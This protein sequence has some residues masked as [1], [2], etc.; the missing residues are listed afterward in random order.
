V[1]HGSG[2]TLLLLGHRAGTTFPVYQSGRLLSGMV[3]LAKP[4]GVTSLDVK[5]EASVSVREIQGGGRSSTIVYSDQLITWDATSA[6]LPD[7]FSFRRIVPVY[8]H[9]GHLLPPTFDSRLSAIPGFRVSVNWSIVIRVTR[10]RTGP[11]SLLL[12]RTARLV[13]P[14][15][16]VPRTRPPSPGPFSVSSTHLSP[17]QPRTSFVDIVPTRKEHTVPIHTQIYLPQSQITPMTEVIPFRITLSAPDSYLKPFLTT[18]PQS[19]FLTL[20]SRASP[21]PAP[22]SGPVSVQLVRRIGADPRETF[23]VV[24]G[25]L[26]TSCTRATTLVE[27]LLSQPMVSQDSISWWGQLRVPLG[28]AGPGG[29]VADRLV[30]QDLLVLTLNVPGMH[31]HSFP[32]KQAVPMRLTT[33]LAGSDALPVTQV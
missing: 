1:K 17:S 22:T 24:V 3:V 7:D 23:V 30:V 25:E 32:F 14:I 31:T 15:G 4:V 6:S 2:I 26:S 19:S 29:F 9:S 21:A 10:T 28:L 18:P 13:V 27:A 20:G 16:Y 8:S 12:R 5:L 33:D 11:L